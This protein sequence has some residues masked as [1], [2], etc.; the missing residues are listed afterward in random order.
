MVVQ[1]KDFH[2]KNLLKNVFCPAG[3]AFRG[4]SDADDGGEDHGDLGPGVE[5]SQGEGVMF[6]GVEIVFFFW[7]GGWVI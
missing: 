6:W 3:D 7:G 5:G 2:Q 1:P 4:A